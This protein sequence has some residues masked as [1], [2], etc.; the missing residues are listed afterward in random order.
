MNRYII[1]PELNDLIAMNRKSMFA[2][3]KPRVDEIVKHC[4]NDCP[5]AKHLI[6]S[7]EKARA[8]PTVNMALGLAIKAYKDKYE[9]L[10]L[11]EMIAMWADPNIS[12]SEVGDKITL[13]VIEMTDE[14]F[15][16]IPEV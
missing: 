8:L 9:G 14:E 10:A 7:Y 1:S 5:V 11:G 4:K 12:D 6:L 16:A 13:E 15:A 2:Y 3:I